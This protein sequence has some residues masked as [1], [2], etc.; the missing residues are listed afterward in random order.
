[1]IP[2]KV[3]VKFY[4]PLFEFQIDVDTLEKWLSP[5][6]GYFSIQKN[7]NTEKIIF[8]L[9][10]SLPYVTYWW[11]NYFEKHSRDKFSYFGSKPTW[12]T[13][14][15]ALKKQYYPIENYDD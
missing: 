9:L 4:I 8:V 15:D 5:L 2:F 3:Q 6:E 10:K 13:F 7:S 11:E 1:V 14:V 12:A